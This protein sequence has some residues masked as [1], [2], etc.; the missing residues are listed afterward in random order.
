VA[1]DPLADIFGPTGSS[2]PLADLFGPQTQA[3]PEL[4]KAFR[5]DTTYTPGDV[6]KSFGMEEVEA[7]KGDIRNAP[8]LTRA[9]QTIET[10]R[11]ER[12]KRAEQAKIDAEKT[13]NEQWA[14]RISFYDKRLGALARFGSGVSHGWDSTVASM[15]AGRADFDRMFGG[16][17]ADEEDRAAKAKAD[18]EREIATA[19]GGGLSWFGQQVGMVAGS[20]YSSG[21]KAAE[22]GAVAASFGGQAAGLPGAVTAGVAGFAAGFAADSF[23]VNA[24]QIAGDLQAARGPNGETIDPTYAHQAAIW[25]GSIMAALDVVGLRFVG[26]PFEAAL[27]KTV[28]KEVAGELADATLKGGIKAAA[29]EYGTAVAGETITETS[30]Q[31]VQDVADDIAKRMSDKDF[32]TVFNDP[33]RRKEVVQNA[34]DTALSVAAGMSVIALPG[35]VTAARGSK[36]AQ[37]DT[38]ELTDV[39]P[40]PQPE[41]VLTD[42]DRASPI[43]DDIILEGKGIA[44]KAIKEFHGVREQHKAVDSEAAGLKR[45]VDV[46]LGTESHNQ[47]YGPHGGLLTSSKGAKGE[48]QVMGGTTTDPG[49]GVR[50]AD[51]NNPDDIARVGREYLAAMMKR[52]GG[53]P[54]K[55]WA[56]YNAGPGALDA[57]LD[58]FGEQWLAHM[59]AETRDYVRKNMKALGGEFVSSTLDLSNEEG[60]A[61]PTDEIDATTENVT[62]LISRYLGEDVT[63]LV[64]GQR[65]AVQQG[66]ETNFGTVRETYGEG[67]GQGVRIDHDNGTTFDETLADAKS[68]G[69]RI[70]EPVG[71]YTPAAP[72]ETGKAEVKVPEVAQ[73]KAAPQ[74]LEGEPTV[75]PDLLGGKDKTAAE[76]DAERFAPGIVDKAEKR[77]RL[78]LLDDAVDYVLRRAPNSAA[79]GDTPQSLKEFRDAVGDP[80]LTNREVFALANEIDR[81]RGT[82]PGVQQEGGKVEEFG[83]HRF[84]IIHTEARPDSGVFTSTVSET[85]FGAQRV[86]GEGITASSEYLGKD[87]EWHNTQ[88]GINNRGTSAERATFATEEEARQAVRDSIT[89]ETEDLKHYEKA[90]EEA[91]SK[92]LTG[93]D[94]S[95]FIRSRVK[96]LQAEAAKSDSQK[97][98]DAKSYSDRRADAAL[99][100][101]TTDRDERVKI[102]LK[103]GVG[104]KLLPGGPKRNSGTPFGELPDTVQTL[105]QKQMGYGAKDEAATDSTAPE[106]ATVGVDDRE[107]SEIVEDFGNIADSMGSGDEKIS[108]V[109][110]EP[111]AGK[112]RLNDKVKAYHKDHGWMTVA[113]AKAKIDE[114]EEHAVAQGRD[115]KARSLNSDK[116]VLS[117]FDLSGE[118]SLPWEQAGY[119]VFR[120]DIQDDP[121]IPGR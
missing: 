78:D 82:G 25:G 65:V 87:G 81:L 76:I 67:E 96:E 49:F 19:P 75:Q 48:M 2:D 120:F 91:R 46:T 100:Y 86:R 63:K 85:G 36:P 10:R 117:L 89:A 84:S 90:G 45:M 43:P 17:T 103:A 1:K 73:P 112:F 83:G 40:G 51:P 64:P 24:G 8:P 110:D 56:A 111:G 50:P 30:Q 74:R 42:D 68:Y 95:A 62:S 59:P 109:F 53:D 55:A 80:K 21:K 38:L 118:W 9:Q 54:R 35:G 13:A 113:E 79:P 44:D 102:M 77:D 98:T 34:V 22:S 47:R 28:A 114:W 15:A 108:H 16:L 12:Q 58:R 93:T 18:A 106:H 26:A 101:D 23:R 7:P 4:A 32:A 20:L 3:S 57:R 99:D 5:G 29:K 60:D 61:D 33:K 52:Y 72:I 119:Q 41:L 107:L 27:R 6:G 94:R 88:S 97:P 116:I 71:T 39:A 66:D 37:P 11:I 69:A 14:D 31:I 115:P 70:R 121:E 104:E 105:I 92:G